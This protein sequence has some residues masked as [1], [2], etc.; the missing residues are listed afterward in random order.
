M[1]S[2]EKKK[3]IL[4]RLKNGVIQYDED[5]VKEAA[6]E[7]VELGMDANEAIFNGLVS[8]MEEVG[9]LFEEQEYFVPELLM[10]ADALYAGLDILKPHVKKM[11]LGV[12]GS[13]VIGTVE[14]DVHD[15]GKNIVKMMFDVAG[16]TVYDL[17]RDVPLDK[18]VEEQLKTDSEL[19][20]LSAMMTTTMVGMQKVIQ[21]LREKNPNVKIM[22][23]GA[24]VSKDIAE[25]WGADGYAPDA[26]NA[27]KEAI[28]MISAL[29]KMREEAESNQAKG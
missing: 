14:G 3:E 15:I 5:G 23:G 7:A 26:N 10:C 12:K 19:V 6:Q 27:L 28:N 8:G 20:C 22:I 9:R 21:K 17:G 13:V 18:F 25:K 11:D 29:K 1:I 4:E 24:P 16:F 2:E